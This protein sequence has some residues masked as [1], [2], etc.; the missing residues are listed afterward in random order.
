VA[1]GRKALLATTN[2][3]KYMTH[4]YTKNYIEVT[5]T[6]RLKTML[7]YTVKIIFFTLLP[8]AIFTFI[9]AKFPLFGMQSF[10]VVSGSMEPTLPVGSVLYTYAPDS[11]HVSDIIT[12][13]T[14]NNIYVTHRIVEVVQDANGVSY[15]TKGDANNAIDSDLVKSSQVVGAGIALLPIIGKSM[16]FARTLPGFITLIILPT[17]IFIGF[18]LWAIKKEIEREVEKKFMLR[19]QGR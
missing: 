10:V 14:A 4:I 1:R 9:T 3:I 6:N 13:K 17:L 18:E 5:T 16:M 12:F 2:G 15:R 7:D 8:L 19:I 11:F